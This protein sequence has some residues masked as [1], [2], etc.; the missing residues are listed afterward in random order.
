MSTFMEYRER[1]RQRLKEKVGDRPAKLNEKKSY[2]EL[3]GEKKAKETFFW[4][5]NNTKIL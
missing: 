3:E 2:R 5:K 1:E 4:Q